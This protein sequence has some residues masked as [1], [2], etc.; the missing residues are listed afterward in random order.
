MVFQTEC[1]NNLGALLDTYQVQARTEGKSPN[2]IRIYTT[3]LSILQ[4]FLKRRGFP[5]DVA[6][7]GPEEIREFID[8]LQNTKAF[9]EHPFT[10]PQQRSLT[11]HTVNCYL[12]AIRAFW[13]WLIAEEY[14]ET[15]PFDKITIPK[16]P[17]KVITPF[18]EEQIRALLGTIDIKSPNGFRDWTII[19]TLLDTGIRVSELTELELDNVN[20]AQRCLKIRGKGDKERIV[21]IGISVQRAIA[22]YINKYRS[23]PTYPLSSNLFLTRDG[24]L[25]TPNRIESIIERYALKAGI[26]G[27]R[28]SPHTF[29]HTFA[30]TYLRN[31]GD[32]FTLQRILG[33]ETLDMVRN[34]VC[35]AQYDLQEAHLRCSPVDN[36][37]IKARSSRTRLH[38][39]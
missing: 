9:M 33:H 38:D 14:I 12:R 29:R 15:N 1:L 26:R 21:P 13:S 31:G 28:A 17:K 27:V 18:S 11:G 20:L 2:T 23:N 37:K 5:V 6:V 22:K 25:L 4:R 36:L 3:A 7:I 39:D 34:Y 32:V 19:L 10:G 30:I 16:P 8:Y 35:L 24:M